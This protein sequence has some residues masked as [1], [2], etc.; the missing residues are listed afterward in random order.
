MNFLYEN[1]KRI[2]SKFIIYLYVYKCIVMYKIYTNNFN[3]KSET[4]LK[5]VKN[6]MKFIKK[7]KGDLN[8]AK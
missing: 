5:S 8:P 6:S 3:F 4:K 1:P 7:W 2:N